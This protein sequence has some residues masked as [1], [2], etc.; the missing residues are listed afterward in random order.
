[1]SR[2]GFN[3]RKLM[4]QRRTWPDSDEETEEAFECSSAKTIRVQY[5]L[6]QYQQQQLLND[7]R[8]QSK[9]RVSW[10]NSSGETK[11]AHRRAPKPITITRHASDEVILKSGGGSASRRISS[12]VPVSSLAGRITPRT[13][14]YSRSSEESLEGVCGTDYNQTRFQHISVPRRA[15]STVDNSHSPRLSTANA[16]GSTPTY[17]PPTARKCSY[18]QPSFQNDTVISLSGVC[19]S[20]THQ[21]ANPPEY[22]DQPYVQTLSGVCMSTS[23][24]P[25]YKANYIDESYIKTPV[26][27]LNG[28]IKTGINNASEYQKSNSNQTP[29]YPEFANG[30]PSP[31]LDPEEADSENVEDPKGLSMGQSMTKPARDSESTWFLGDGDDDALPDNVQQLIWE[32]DAAFKA[33]S[34]ALAEANQAPNSSNLQAKELKAQ[35]RHLQHTSQVL[36]TQTH[37][38]KKPVLSSV[39][40]PTQ[41]YPSVRDLVSPISPTSGR[42]TVASRKSSSP[43]SPSP[44]ILRSPTRGTSISKTKRGPKSPGRPKTPRSV[45]TELSPSKAGPSGQSSKSLNNHRHQHSYHRSLSKFNLAADNVTE[46]LFNGPRGRFGL[47]RIEADELVTPSKVEQFRQA[48]LAREEVEAEADARRPASYETLHSMVGSMS[49]GNLTNST[50]T[51]DTPIE[52]FQFQDLPSRIGLSPLVEVLTPRSFDI[53]KGNT[54]QAPFM[55]EPKTSAGVT[56]GLE[57]G[58]TLIVT[59]PPTP[60]QTFSRAAPNN[61]DAAS[62]QIFSVSDADESM[63]L[64]SL[65][66]QRLLPSKQSR[67]TTHT[68]ANS[69]SSR[70]PILPTIPEVKITAPGQTSV[71]SSQSQGRNTPGQTEEDQKLATPA[72]RVVNPF[73]REDNDHLWLVSPAYTENVPTIQHGPI[74]LAK[75]DLV[76]RGAINSIEAKLMASPDETMDWIAFQMAILGGAGDLYSNPD[77]FLT[78]DAQEDL[79]DDLCEWFEGFGLSANPLGSLIIKEEKPKPTSISLTPPTSSTPKA[80]SHTHPSTRRARPQLKQNVSNSSKSALSPE[81]IVEETEDSD[82]NMPIPVTTEHPSGFWNTRPFDASRFPTGSGCGIKRWTLEGHPKRYQGPGI[83]VDKANTL[84]PRSNTTKTVSS[85]KPLHSAKSARHSRRGIRESVD[86]L[87][88]SPMLDLVMTTAVDGSKDFVPMGYNLGHDLGD[89]LKWESEHVVAP[90]YY[91]AD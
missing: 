76:N 66:L 85:P 25:T 87:P 35:L 30:V 34:A 11:R 16:S 45:L 42:G 26:G 74:R 52:P 28:P 55:T 53:N 80:S 2:A 54:Q 78:R 18:E 75:D 72:A 8:Y 1:M 70:I 6:E 49:D 9:D 21:P 56:K 57:Q 14:L 44:N 27:T 86:S 88:Q 29:Q 68:R 62:S 79:A 4:H 20:T 7:G 39:P 17:A 38:T 10:M 37:S 69:S 48:R 84:P 19:I 90:G 82:Q 31:P 50:T 43:L 46:R 22:T 13:P 61:S 36:H 83:D 5:E 58:Q 91:G 33:V 51:D 40:T 24:Q 41:T 60:P 63:S 59:P 65:G 23:P 71:A 12:P 15:A 64:I 67:K 3:I 77:D 89:F 81:D 32:T 73:F 47:H